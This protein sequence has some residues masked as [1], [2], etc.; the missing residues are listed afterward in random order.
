MKNVS[1]NIDTNGFNDS[2]LPCLDLY[3]MNLCFNIAYKSLDPATKHGCIAV[4]K[5]GGILTTGYNGPP[6]NCIDSSIPL[7]RPEKYDWM[8][9][10][11]ENC[12]FT[13][14]RNGISLRGSHMYITGMPCFPCLLAMVQVG[15]S[16][17]TY[18]PLN[19]YMLKEEGYFDKYDLLFSIL[20]TKV[21]FES[22]KYE[23]GLIEINPKAGQLI[24]YCPDINFNIV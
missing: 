24:K 23:A 21:I 14:A 10:S 4:D 5:E 11:E 9:H 12:I 13:A 19:S 15:V 20:K 6:R 8:I 3:M 22:F 7:E 2:G 18:G 17:I 16:K 1:K